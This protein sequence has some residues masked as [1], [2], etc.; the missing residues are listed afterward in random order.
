MPFGRIFSSIAKAFTKAVSAIPG[1][2][3]FLAGFSWTNVF[4]AI[5][6]TLVMTAVSSL[7]AP[8]P[9][10]RNSS[11]MQQSYQNQTTNRSAMTK[12]PIIS[13]D[14]V[15][16]TT[17]K[18]GGI[19]YATSTNNNKDLHMIVQ[20]AS[21]E[22]QSFDTIFFNDEALTLSSIGNDSNGIARFKVTSPD[23]YKQASRFANSE[24]TLIVSDLKPVD[25]ILTQ[26]LG[27]SY[28]VDGHALLQGTT[29]VK[30][31][32][33]SVFTVDTTDTINIGGVDYAVS[34]GGTASSANNRFEL[35]VVLSTGI[36]RQVNAYR[37]NDHS[38]DLQV[39]YY[40]TNQR[41]TNVLPFIS[42]TTTTLNSA[43]MAKHK[44]ESTTDMTVR[45]KTHLGSD[46]QVADE[47]LVNEVTEWTTDHRLRGIA[48][49]YVKLKY[50]NEA[51]PNGI[52]N[53]SATIR[54]KKLL[55]FRDSSTAYSANPVL[56]LYDFLTDTRVGMGIATSNIDTTS[57]TTVA[58]TCD[59]TV[60][61]AAGGTEKRYEA[62]GIVYSD[63]APMEIIEDL[64]TSF[65][66][67]LN[68]S[69]GKFHLSGGKYVS[70]SITLT[71]ADFRGGIQLKT[72][73]SRRDLFNTV[74]GIFASPD[75]QYQ[76]TDYPM[77]TSSTFVTE[78]GESIF[79]DIDLPFT[80][81][82]TMAQ[83]IA[84]IALF[85]NRQQLVFTA[86]LKLTGFKLQVGDT[87]QVT[88]SR[89]GFSNKIFEVAD[90][91]FV[92]SE[93]D[94]G[95]DV[96]LKETASS[97][98]DWD[99]EES[100][101]ATDNTTL[102]SVGT[103]DAPGLS[104]T[105]KLRAY[106]GTITTVLLIDV[107]TSFGE[108]I[109]FEVEYR[110]TNTM[111]DFKSVGRSKNTKFEVQ[112]VEDAAVYEVRARAINAFNVGSSFTSTSHEVI[113]KTNPPS[114]VTNFNVNV[115]GGMANL[116]WE[117]VP[118]LD[119]SHYVVRHT[120]QTS[121]PDYNTGI[122]VANN[123]SSSTNS[124]AIPAQTGTYMIK[125]VD[126]LGLAST[127]S[128]KKSVV[129]NQIDES[130]N[131]VSTQTESTGFSGTKSGCEVV[132]RDSTNFLQIILGELFDSHTGNFD[133]APD[134]FD[135][136][137]TATSNAEATYDFANNPIDLGAI[138]N[139]QVTATVTSSRFEENT[140][141]DSFSGFFDSRDGLFDG[142][143][144]EAD[145]VN[146]VIQLSLSNDNSTYTDF[147]DYILGYYKA[148][149]IKLRLKLTTQ[150]F[151]ATPA[152]STLSATIDMPDRTVAVDDIAS[153][154]ASGGKAVTF[155]PAF[156][157]LEGLGIS[158]DNLNS[159][160]FY[161]ITSKSATG[162]TIKFKNSSGT[163]VDRTFGYVAKG[164]GFVESS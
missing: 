69:N 106:G 95:V 57:F 80:T 104:V 118:D 117:E 94:V 61:L 134:N 164:F 121:S 26:V 89:Y 143:T 9:R 145:D 63:I 34:S 70:P 116:S 88:H 2:E 43:I 37:I 45:I 50:D 114:N 60:A 81:S 112:N 126:V 153:G 152:I 151:G 100:E 158:A 129:L 32:N 4:T 40:N 19:L 140:L 56:A 21:H 44:F 119:I 115:V 47:D 30:L 78:D 64:L 131:V 127:T 65:A 101:F 25:N 137:G 97:V 120:T 102:P 20:I 148:R 160:D 161:E 66:G 76:P 38:G 72:K 13:R 113:G 33:D 108:N 14:M 135:D 91:R 36:V 82:S 59:E 16:G 46:D 150:N 53:I 96:V 8:R 31:I 156:K 125:A 10:N 18:S 75:T 109:E 42:G 17:R 55:D 162:F 123:V 90:W 23:K 159:G 24:Q 22:I 132:N 68:Y 141:F 48:Y 92:G 105:D 51:F 73:A 7:L 111:E 163:V 98:Y 103:V 149:Y 3:A 15:Y 1:G 99:A 27:N 146:A 130:F 12:Q 49:I 28:Y 139:S 29:S 85:K 11:L 107:S 133:D 58:N 124:I 110:N 77:V 84:K 62:H 71:D 93:T 5:V 144:L 74:K 6:T 136:G 142:D 155:S 83:R 67:V 41:K 157:S 54:G 79:V 52:P 128:A 138:Y 154:T 147:Q 86:P 35:T 122:V 39:T 87:V